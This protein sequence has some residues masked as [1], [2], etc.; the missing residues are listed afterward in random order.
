MV[1]MLLASLSV[2]ADLFWAS[3][4]GIWGFCWGFCWK[5]CRF[6]PKIPK[7]LPR[8]WERPIFSVAKGVAGTVSLP[9]F[10]V[11][12]PFSSV[13]F[14]FSLFSFRFLFRFLPFFPFLSLFFCF[15]PFFSVFFRFFPFHFQKKRGDTV[16]E[17]PFAKP[18]CKKNTSYLLKVA[19]FGPDQR[20][21]QNIPKI[22]WTA[23]KPFLGEKRKALKARVFGQKGV[24]FWGLYMSNGNF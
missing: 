4:S 23:K 19:V 9:I 1:V 21:A 12:F 17:T 24:P 7:S 20:T 8:L 11:F 5:K 10:S 3:E 14:V 22:G 13:F 15:L 2:A 6:D 16:R 18:R